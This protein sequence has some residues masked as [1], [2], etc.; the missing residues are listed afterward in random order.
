ME[1]EQLRKCFKTHLKSKNIVVYVEKELKE[2]LNLPL[3]KDFTVLLA[4]TVPIDIALET[5]AK[6]FVPDANPV[7]KP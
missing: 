2:G 1:L 6:R 5:K 4:D 3:V 7:E